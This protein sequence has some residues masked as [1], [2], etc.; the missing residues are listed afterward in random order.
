[1]DNA[2]HNLFICE[3]GKGTNNRLLWYDITAHSVH[4]LGEHK[5]SSGEFSGIITAEHVIGPGWY[6]LTNQAEIQINSPLVEEGQL[7]AMYH[8]PS[9]YPVPPE[10]LSFDLSS[11]YYP[12]RKG[13]PIYFQTQAYDPNGV[14]FGYEDDPNS[15]D[16]IISYIWNFGD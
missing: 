9:A 1:M 13:I 10:I 14:A 15:G 7:L 12:F 11:S 2:G 4:V 5:K 8:P 6:L 16:K 3:D